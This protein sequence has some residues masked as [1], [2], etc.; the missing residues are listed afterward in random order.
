VNQDVGYS[1]RTVNH[2]SILNMIRRNIALM[3]RNI[4]DSDLA[5]INSQHQFIIKKDGS[6]YT[7]DGGWFGG[8]IN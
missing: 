4:S 6:D 5:D 2:P 8:T 1:Y 7:I 3:S